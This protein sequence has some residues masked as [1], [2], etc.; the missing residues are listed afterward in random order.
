MKVRQAVAQPIATR[1]PVKRVVLFL[2]AFGLAIAVIIG[3]TFLLIY[4]SA[5]R[6]RRDSKAVLAGVTVKSFFQLA[7]DNTFPMGLVAV[8]VAFSREIETLV[9]KPLQHSC[10]LFCFQ[11]N[12]V[13]SRK[14]SG[15]KTDMM[16]HRF[17]HKN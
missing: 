9:A 17:I 15:D 6:S 3:L 7:A 11:R 4:N 5:A 8:S 10:P 1:P 16:C 2:L 12:A 14:T 13:C